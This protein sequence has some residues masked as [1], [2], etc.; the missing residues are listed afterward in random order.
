MHWLVT[1]LQHTYA[2]I[3]Y[4]PTYNLYSYIPYILRTYI[5]TTLHYIPN[6]TTLHNPTHHQ[7]TNPTNVPT[8][9]TY[10]LYA[11]IPT[12]TPTNPTTYPACLPNTYLLH[13]CTTYLLHLC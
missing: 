4:I 2:L 8:D 10:L 1:Y 3:A 7:H 6:P 5:H 11:Y 12:L 9:P 13:L